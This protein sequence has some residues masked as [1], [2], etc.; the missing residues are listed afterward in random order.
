MTAIDFRDWWKQSV[1]KLFSPEPSMNYQK[2]FQH[3]EED[4]VQK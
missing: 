1:T 3:I 2:P 4:D